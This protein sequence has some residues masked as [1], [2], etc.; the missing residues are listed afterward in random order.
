MIGS[1]SPFPGGGGGW[2]GGGGP[3]PLLCRRLP[4]IRRFILG[5]LSLFSEEVEQDAEEVIGIGIDADCWMRI[6]WVGLL[7]VPEEDVGSYPPDML[8]MM[9]G[10]WR[11]R[12]EVEE[13]VALLEAE[14]LGP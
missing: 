8:R 13:E 14:K 1:S 5:S 2:E 6:F 4:D 3:P 9:I 7:P 12:S 11:W 10:F